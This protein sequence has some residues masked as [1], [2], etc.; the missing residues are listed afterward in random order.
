MEK[1]LPVQGGLGGASGNAV[2]ALLALE[3]ALKKRLPGP[4]RLR[5]AAEVGS[6]LPLFLVGG[7]CLGVGR[8]EEVYPLSDLPGTLCVIATPEVAVST[9]QAFRDWDSM[10]LPQG[11]RPISSG[12]LKGTAEAMPFPKANKQPGQPMPKNRVGHGFSPA[13]RLINKSGALALEGKLTASTPSDRMNEF[14]RRLSSWLSE[15]ELY[16]VSPH[17]AEAGPRPHFSTL[18]VPGSK[19]TSNRSS[20]LSIPNCV[21]LSV[22][23]NGRGFVCFAVRIGLGDLW[24]VCF[25]CFSCEGCRQSCGR[26]RPGCG[27]DHAD[28]ASIGR[29]FS[30][31]DL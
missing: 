31:E 13:D 1:S 18:S 12:R 6:D 23:S 5:I 30:F 4:E 7:T 3:L 16:P 27:Y 10:Q 9:P 19:T 15:S 2:G 28:A 24:V 17:E 14:S 25:P 8:G 20:F 21:R 11:L 29:R 22:C 26:W